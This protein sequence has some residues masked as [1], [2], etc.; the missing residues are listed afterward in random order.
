MKFNLITK[1]WCGFQ[2]TPLDSCINGRLCTKDVPSIVYGVKGSSS[3]TYVQNV[4][5]GKFLNKELDVSTVD[6]KS[7]A[8]VSVSFLNLFFIL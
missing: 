5:Y 4:A 6:R 1:W 7:A 2:D 8:T 3:D